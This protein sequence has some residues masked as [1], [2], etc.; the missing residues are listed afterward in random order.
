MTTRTATAAILLMA[1]SCASAHRLDEYLQGALLSVEKSR[2]QAQITLTPGLA[3]LPAVL[4]EIDTNA[5]GAISATEQR[6]YAAKVL[7]D[8]SFTIDGHPLTPQLMSVRFPSLAE[9]QDGNGAIQIECA[10]ALPPGRRG[11][12]KLVFE[13]LHLRAIGVYQVNAL[14][15]RDPDIRIVAQHRNF[16][17]SQYEMEYLQAGVPA[18]RPSLAW[19]GAA[20]LLL[21]AR[22]AWLWRRRPAS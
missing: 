19:L 8:L 9:M 21:G 13:N 4:A 17:Q 20:T 11:N 6:A 5:D 10:A 12:R 3:V 2:M 22:F 14:V 7:R 1:G 15:P 16:S 18:Y